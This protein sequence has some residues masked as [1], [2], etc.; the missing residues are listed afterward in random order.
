M[1]FWYCIISFLLFLID[2]CLFFCFDHQY[3]YLVLYFF[4]FIFQQTYSL[5]ALAPCV[6]L[7]SLESFIF[8]EQPIVS[9]AYLL[10]F[11]LMSRYLH[12]TLDL[13]NSSIFLLY[14][15]VLG[16]Q[17]LSE[18]WFISNFNGFLMHKFGVCILV[19]MLGLF[20]QQWYAHFSFSPPKKSF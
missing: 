13:K 17:Q 19:Y 18:Y 9:F 10:P 8:Y 3:V 12:H 14:C 20:I 6:I 2:I 5:A 1:F 7:Q 16:L 15:F 4:C 11:M